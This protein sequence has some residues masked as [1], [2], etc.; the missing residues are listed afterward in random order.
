MSD[1]THIGLDNPA[2]HGRLRQPLPRA[3]SFRAGS[4]PKSRPAGDYFDQVYTTAEI[5]SKP[6]EEKARPPEFMDSQNPEFGAVSELPAI[7]IVKPQPFVEPADKRQQ[8]SHVLKRGMVRLPS[9]NPSISNP[10]ARRY[11]KLQ[12]VLIGMACFVFVSG[13][14]VSI[15]T[16][17]TNHSAAAQV[18]ALSKKS[19]DQSTTN[20]N[21][22]LALPST[23][24]P[25]GK[26]INQYVVAPDLARYLKIPKLGVYARVLQVG[27]TSDGALGTPS[28]VYDTAWYTGSAKPG[29]PGAT[30]IDGH[31]S[32][33]TTHGIFYGIKT[34]VAGDNIQIV[35]GD[36]TVLTYQV[37]KVQVYDS[38]NVDMRA[39]ITPITAGKSGLNLIT[40]TGRVKPGTSEF[41]QRVVV[42]AQQI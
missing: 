42:F 2:F 1:R 26:S 30:L 13:L 14:A 38:D 12:V 4:G 35:R 21:Q 17:L 34:L 20:D 3:Q 36:G 15:Q 32:S 7:T 28:N 19:A 23:E 27:I 25:T 9:A 11:S 33:W 6:A 16:L 24:K 5:S 8:R 37:V 40:C 39:A 29:Q 31:V 18:S 41:N 22:S 10:K